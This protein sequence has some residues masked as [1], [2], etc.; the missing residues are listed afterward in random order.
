M[1][2]SVIRTPYLAEE[3][4]TAVWAAYRSDEVTYLDDRHGH[5]AAIVPASSVQDGK[6][7]VLTYK[8]A[9]LLADLIRGVQAKAKL[10]YYPRG[11]DS[12]DNPMMLILRAFTDQQGAFWADDKDI[13][14]AFVW[15]SGIT[16]QF[17]GVEVLIKALD[18]IDG[19]HGMTAVMAVIDHE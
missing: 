1:A 6:P 17:L 11:T 8:Q 13:R 14:D 19:K 15:C 7:R 10:R 4:R 5:I 12:A 9:N 18:N 16:E 2:D 3:I